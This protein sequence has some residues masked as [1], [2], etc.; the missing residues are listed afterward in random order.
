MTTRP[1]SLA[2]ATK[3]PSEIEVDIAGLE[4]GTQILVSDLK[5]PEGA[6]AAQE[7]EDLV[8]NITAQIS[9]EALDAELA[10]DDAEQGD[11]AEAAEEAAAE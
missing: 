11:A 10:D 8:V 9:Q 4:A 1:F 6:E 2:E 7:A 3:I 5:L